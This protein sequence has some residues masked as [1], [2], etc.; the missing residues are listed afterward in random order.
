MK[1]DKYK[2]YNLFCSYQKY[3]CF[4]LL[5]SFK[6]KTIFQCFA[7]VQIILMSNLFQLKFTE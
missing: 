5:T 4:E 3:A 6:F 2:G 7:F 1:D